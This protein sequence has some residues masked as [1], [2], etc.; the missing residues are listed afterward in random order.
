VQRK[1]LTMN[2]LLHAMK[3]RER[4]GWNVELAILYM[5]DA[6]PNLCRFLEANVDQLTGGFL[7]FL[8][9]CLHVFL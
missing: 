7:F 4:R 6:A 2:S 5:D 1:L 3:A 9:V 8:V